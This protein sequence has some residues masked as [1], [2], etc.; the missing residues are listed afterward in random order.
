MVE[1]GLGELTQLKWLIDLKN[2]KPEE[3]KKFWL[4]L[5]DILDEMFKLTKKMQEKLI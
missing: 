1:M 2:E 4:D 3:Y 5:E